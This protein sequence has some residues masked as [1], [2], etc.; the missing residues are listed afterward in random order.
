[1]RVFKPSARYPIKLYLIYL[2]CFGLF[3][4][5][6]VFLGLIPELG[7]WYVFFYML[8]NA[9][10]LVPLLALIPLYCRRISYSLD[11][12]EITVRKGLVTQV[13]Q[14]VPLSKVT[15]LSLNRGPFDRLLGLG[16]L[17]VHT[18]GF[19]G[20]NQGPE[21]M[22][23]GLEDYEAVQQAV[24]AQVRATS[25]AEAAP[26]M[27]PEAVSLAAGAGDAH[28]LLTDILDEL[29]GIRGALEE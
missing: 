15:N 2:I 18:A 17:Q 4:F 12:Q 11:A 21:A 26:A 19:S 20:Q 28:Q 27:A 1:M 16:T 29:R 9:L 7:I 5:P 3:I 13:V 24:L 14:T 25:R 10:W 23:V 6:W 22:L 8:A